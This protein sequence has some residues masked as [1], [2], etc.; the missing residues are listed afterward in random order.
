L[1]RLALHD[2][3][4]DADVPADELVSAVLDQQLTFETALHHEVYEALSLAVPRL[5][6]DAF[7]HLVAVISVGPPTADLIDALPAELR[8]RFRDRQVLEFLNWLLKHRPTAPRPTALDE[9]NARHPDWGFDDDHVEFTSFTEVHSS[10]IEDEW[11]WSP[12]EYHQKIVESPKDALAALAEVS[13]RKDFWWGGG[14]MV[15]TTVERWPDDGFALWA[16]ADPAVRNCV[17]AGWAMA[18]LGL[19]QMDAIIR[20]LTDADL[21]E[22]V[23]ETA[24]LLYPWSNDAA[25]RSRWI[26]R[27]DARAL[28]RQTLA[29]LAP[30]DVPEAGGDLYTQAINSTIGVLAEFWVAAAGHDVR[31]EVAPDGQLGAGVAEAL[32]DLL[33]P[34]PQ[35]PLALAPLVA[36]IDFLVR[37]DPSWAREHLLTAIDPRKLPWAEIEPLWEIVVRGRISEQLLQLCLLDWLPVALAAA[38]KASVGSGP[39]SGEGTKVTNGLA[40]MAALVAVR[41]TMDDEQR[42]EWTKTLYART[43]LRSG[44]HWIE[45]VR[46]FVRD[47]EPDARLS[48][49]HRW[50]AATFEERVAGIP[51]TLSAQE[52]TAFVGWVGLVDEA[53]AVDAAVDRLLSARKGFASSTEM[54]GGLPVPQEALRANPTAWAR[55][56]LG[57]LGHTTVVPG[58]L[59]GWL[60][61]AANTV[62]DAGAD[63]ATVTALKAA[64]FGMRG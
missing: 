56:I 60:N 45:D 7:D 14:D 29:A 3:A 9:I 61:D 17:I 33:R 4:V 46:H 58:G 40:R 59:V 47:L 44:V 54:W 32:E 48:L 30:A 41:S 1:R 63:E 6:D 12:E 20:M 21:G 11:P 10:T 26:G 37:V 18:P 23:R 62:A 51:R 13:P 52:V 43:D 5:D 15:R 64:L 38:V 27:P 16:D 31:H 39:D 53:T 34:S 57:T 36:Q 49:W 50:M 2:L 24:R 19:D 42:I 28:A 55:L 8:E 35:R 22:H 25:I